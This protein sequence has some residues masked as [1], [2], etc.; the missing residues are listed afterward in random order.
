MFPTIDKK[1]SKKQQKPAV[2]KRVKTPTILQMEAVECGAAALAIIM[3]YYGRKVPLEKLRVACGVSRD[4]LKATNIMK[5]A[6]SYNMKAKGFAKS[7]DKLK[8]AEMPLIIFW[9]FNHFLVLEGFGKDKVYLSDPAQGRYQVSYEEFDESYTGVAIDLR[10]GEGFEKANEKEGLTTALRSRISNSQ[11]SLVFIVLAS[12]FLVIPGLI[13]PSFTQMFIDQFLVNGRSNFVMPLLLAMGTVFGVNALLIF[14]QQYYLLRLETKLALAT[15]SKFLWHIMHLPIAFFTQRSAGEVG[16]RVTLND[17][18]A[19]LLSGDLANAAL[20]V[21]VVVFY[22]LLMFSYDVLLTTIG[23][24]IAAVNVVCLQLVSRARKDSN[25]RLVNES[26]KLMGSTMSGISMIETLKASGREGDFFTTWSGHL[27]K[28]MNAQQE[29]G[30]LSLR[31]NIIP[32][33]LMALNTAVIMGVGAL[34]VMDGNMTLGML[35]A[36]LYLMNSFI[37]PVNHLVAVGSTLQ[38]TEGDMNRIDDVLDYEVAEEFS[39]QDKPE[40]DNTT[41]RKLTGALELKDIKFGYTHAMPALIEDFSLKLEPGSRVAL[42]GGSGSGKSTVARLVAGLY[43]PWEGELLFDGKPRYNIPRSVMNTSLA[44]IDQDISMFKGTIKE[45][46]AFWDDTIPERDIIQA[47]KDAMIHEVIASRK[48]GYDSEVSE[49]GTNF[50]GGQRQ[51]LEIA[52]ALVL[53][54][55]LLVM[56][57]ATSALDPKSEK[58][59]MDNIKRRGCTCLIVAHRLSTIRDCDEIIVMKFGKIVERG[60]HEELIARDGLYAELIN[61]K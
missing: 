32:P 36:F 15:S 60:T 39:R 50:S 23:I 7:I 22:A 8:E 4:G 43:D 44:V 40:E 58:I 52:R 13:I 28:V 20:N 29:L 53:N 57:E 24:V 12:L 42:V 31:L 48:N 59:I 18:V 55:S 38:E 3:G 1:K 54:P 49:K 35:V 25:R 26:G 56:D 10:P 27:A 9:N 34:R 45:N 30:W 5:A 6:R 17:K 41:M 47:A 19:R 37:R 11:M 2:S 21:I 46:I 14:I 33:F 61:S 16:N 51:R